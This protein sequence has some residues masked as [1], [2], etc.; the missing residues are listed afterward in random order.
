L[1]W[2]AWATQP[3]GLGR[4]SANITSNLME[5]VRHRES[6][7]AAVETAIMMPLF[8]FMILGLLQLLLMHQARLMTKYAAY[9]AVRA[10]ALGKAEKPFMVDAARTVL[11][12]LAARPDSAS[13]Y[14]THDP[15]AYEA[16]WADLTTRGLGGRSLPV[17]EVT[18][19]GPLRAHDA[20]E[21][22][23]WFDDPTASSFA[24]S[25]RGIDRT[26]LSAQVTFYYRLV[27]P[28]VNGVLWWMVLG[29]ENPG[30]MQVLRTGSQQRRVAMAASGEK[31]QLYNEREGAGL[32]RTVEDLRGL[33]N[34]NIYVLPIRASYSMRMH[35]TPGR[36][37]LPQQNYCVIPWTK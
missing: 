2:F 1:K 13:M 36:G 4:L 25:G 35:S 21:G 15:A 10:G 23:I 37:T 33:A 34:D 22:S 30:L 26:R 24:W 8:V 14:K 31:T 3:I 18:I 19:C 9:K 27:V 29:Q 6:G 20:E 11:L 5:M 32:R 28:F 7:Q 16:A 12:P 17:V